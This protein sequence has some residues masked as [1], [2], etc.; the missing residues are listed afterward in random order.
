MKVHLS[1]HSPVFGS[2]SDVHA[3]WTRED[4][5]HSEQRA[6]DGLMMNIKDRQFLTKKSR[7]VTCKH[8]LNKDT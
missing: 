8:C 3:Q 2:L 6:C 1:V 4:I 7:F 5:I